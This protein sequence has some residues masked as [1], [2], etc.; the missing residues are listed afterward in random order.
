MND[1]DTQHSHDRAIAS[2]SHKLCHHASV[3]CV[4][5]PVIKLLQDRG[6]EKQKSRLGISRR[7]TGIQKV[8][9]PKAQ[10]SL[11]PVLRHAI[12]SLASFLTPDPSSPQATAVPAATAVA[13]LAPSATTAAAAS[14]PSTAGLPAAVAARVPPSV[15]SGSAANPHIDR[16][17]ALTSRRA[18]HLAGTRVKIYCS[19]GGKGVKSSRPLCASG[20]DSS[21]S[22]RVKQ[23]V[24]ALDLMIWRCECARKV[25]TKGAPIPVSTL[26]GPNQAKPQAALQP[27]PAARQIVNQVAAR[28]G[29]AQSVPASAQLP[30]QGQAP[31][32]SQPEAA[33][34]QYSP[35]APDL[36]H[37]L[38]GSSPMLQDSSLILT[39]GAASDQ[40]HSGSDRLMT[41][42][43]QQNS[44]FQPL[45]TSA[46]QH[47][48][49]K[50]RSPSAGLPSAPGPNLEPARQKSPGSAS[51]AGL[52]PAT[53]AV[54]VP[55]SSQSQ[56]PYGV[57]SAA[58]AAN[59]GD[60][61][62][63]VVTSQDAA[64]QLPRSSEGL[65]DCSVPMQLP[66]A[67][68]GQAMYKGHVLSELQKPLKAQDSIGTPDTPDT[69]MLERHAAL[70]REHSSFSKGTSADGLQHD[71]S[72]ATLKR[73]E[74]L[75][76][77]GLL[78]L[79]MSDVPP[80]EELE[81][82]MIAA[83]LADGDVFSDKPGA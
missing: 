16:V 31:S 78:D 61:T 58:A 11:L 49:T 22:R 40:Q 48:S 2:W 43:T 45:S 60:H 51:L 75:T 35:E 42:A 6:L 5:T 52:I 39:H 65:Q 69:D 55:S 23:R 28:L 36:I 30:A 27:A 24:E 44:A 26:S 47:V 67:G 1:A 8:P 62:V 34:R 10:P 50:S 41:H 9:A 37:Q 46:S 19:Q 72:T 12:T 15:Q 59:I 70:Q 76:T 17:I 81:P 82:D 79:A 73:K 66:H 57:I 18:P 21:A 13:G 77:S 64:Y 56:A 7:N 68:L 4:I 29:V 14:E 71:H 20:A 38:P 33:D 63:S 54:T 3:K 80:T 83:F 32:S 25:I 53:T 74:V